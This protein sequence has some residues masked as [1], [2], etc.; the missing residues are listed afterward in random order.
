MSVERLP[1]G[2]LLDVMDW[3]Q[4]EHVSLV[5]PTGTGKSHAALQLI[6]QRDYV[7][8]FG[9]KPLD[10]T[11]DRLTA[12]RR[13]DRF[14]RVKKWRDV[15]QRDRRVLLW[16]PMRGVRDRAT[17]ADQFTAALDDC[18]AQGRWCLFADETAYM[19]RQLGLAD[20]FTLI[21]QQGR[22]IGLSLVTCIQ[23]PAFVPLEAYDAPTHLFFW[24]DNDERNLRR[25]G[26]IGWLDAGTIRQ[27]VARLG[28]HEALYLNSRT[29]FQAVTRAP[30]R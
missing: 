5:G 9:T 19:C 14:R 6:P 27:T 3:R 7:V 26:G 13:P 15:R 10:R 20:R 17:Q 4:G 18:F 21:W 8:A 2:E 29:G 1:W 30:A 28:Q 24:R 23:R 22:S 11:L 12:A 25:I 16:P